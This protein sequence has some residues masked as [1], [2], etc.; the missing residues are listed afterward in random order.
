MSYPLYMIPETFFDNLP[1]YLA[2]AGFTV[3]KE[4]ETPPKLP[5]GFNE[6]LPGYR[7]RC[8][9]AWGIGVRLVFSISVAPMAHLP[10][11]YI[12][13]MYPSWP[14]LFFWTT[15]NKRKRQFLKNIEELLIQKGARLPAA[16]ADRK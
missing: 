13:R 16:V 12:D 14:G 15:T 7:L 8:Y 6:R 3:H 2:E 5:S 11:L 10:V 1:A 4:S 9:G